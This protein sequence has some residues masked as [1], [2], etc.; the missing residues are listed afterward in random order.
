MIPKLLK[1]RR[2]LGILLLL[3]GILVLGIVQWSCIPIL[4]ESGLSTGTSVVSMSAGQV[5][6]SAAPLKCLFGGGPLPMVLHSGIALRIA[7]SR[8]ARLPDPP[9]SDHDVYSLAERPLR[10]PPLA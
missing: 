3:S 10:A 8:A 5:S 2:P 1:P 9:V 4:V 6:K 7:A